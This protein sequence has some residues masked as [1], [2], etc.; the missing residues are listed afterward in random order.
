MPQDTNVQ[1]L[2]INKLTQAQYNSIANP[3]DTELYLTPDTS[4]DIN[5]SNLSSQG[6]SYIA[7][8][9]MPSDTIINLT[10]GASGTTYTVPANG[11]VYSRVYSNASGQ[12][13]FLRGIPV[14]GGEYGY[15][16]FSSGANQL[17]AAAIPVKKGETFSVIYSTPT[18]SSQLKFFYAVGSE[19]EAS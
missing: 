5:A 4:V 6:M 18:T 17:L 16:M 15:R 8:M 10:L 7:S 13:F 12:E 14:T 11:W 9:G 3:S 2:I 1:N 19:S